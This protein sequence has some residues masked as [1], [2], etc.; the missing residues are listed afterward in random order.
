M[1][2]LTRVDLE[3]YQ[4]KKWVVLADIVWTDPK[5]GTI[6]IPR[7]FI[8]DLASTPQIMHAMPWF[9]PSGEGRYGSLP[10]DYLYASHR[11]NWQDVGDDSVFSHAETRAWCDAVLYQALTDGGMSPRL[12][13]AYWM[14]VRIGGWMAWNKRGDGLAEQDF[15]PDSYWRAAAMAHL[16][17]TLRP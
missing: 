17:K 2:F 4:G 5:F 16:S 15:V 9:D 7:E 10:H 12:A 3:V 6:V 14:G 11:L 1:P 8:T 13:R